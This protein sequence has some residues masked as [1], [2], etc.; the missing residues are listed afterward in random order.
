MTYFRIS[1]PLCS[2]DP[3]L[4][5]ATCV[6]D[7]VQ[8]TYYCQCGP[9]WTG[10]TCALGEKCLQLPPANEVCEGYVFTGVCASMR[11][12]SAS[13]PGFRGVSDTSPGQTPPGRHP[14]G[15][16]PPWADTPPGRHPPLGR[17]P[18][19]RHPPWADSQQAGSTHPT[20]MHSCLEIVSNTD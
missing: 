10:P 15:R 4:N 5:G 20:G 9:N 1:A 19:G 14:L 13:A 2:S 7:D 17:H 6:Q 18:P 12:V 16:H 11:R 8:A 3:C